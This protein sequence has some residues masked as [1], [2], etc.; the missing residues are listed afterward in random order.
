MDNATSS[1]AS[2]LFAF[3]VACARARQNAADDAAASR[4]PSWCRRAMANVV[5]HAAVCAAFFM[6]IPAAG[7][8]F[9]G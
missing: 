4:R 1:L 2:R 9:G 7:M 8:A 3:D 5:A 6:T